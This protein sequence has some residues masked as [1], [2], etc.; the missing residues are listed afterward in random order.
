M[1]KFIHH[2]LL[3]TL[4]ILFLPLFRT[5]MVISSAMCNIDSWDLMSS[6]LAYVTP[7]NKLLCWIMYHMYISQV[8][9]ALWRL[10]S[11]L[12]MCHLNQDFCPCYVE[13]PSLVLPTE[14]KSSAHPLLSAA[15]CS[16]YQILKRFWQK[17]TLMIFWRKEL[18]LLLDAHLC[19]STWGA[20][21]GGGFTCNCFFLH[22]GCNMEWKE[23]TALNVSLP[24]ETQQKEINTQNVLPL[25]V[26]M[27]W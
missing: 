17:S 13:F 7:S 3:K 23:N 24:L 4:F 19:C 1:L 5:V 25:G 12:I 16:A 22:V 15:Y 10:I 20:A 27:A 11:V 18:C 6:C 8:L 21:L 26:Q 9:P 2:P 14:I